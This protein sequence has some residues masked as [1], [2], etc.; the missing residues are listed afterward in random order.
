MTVEPGTVCEACGRRVNKPKLPTSPDTK[1][2]SIGRLPLER[3][4]LLDEAMDGL[5]HVT[6]AVHLSYPKGT[7]LEA[8]CVLGGIHREELK[9]LFERDPA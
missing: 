3:Q 8:L 9:L 7:L 4:Q 6:G 2:V 1:V 5:M